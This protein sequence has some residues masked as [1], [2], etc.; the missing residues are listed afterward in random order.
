[1]R[2]YIF[3]VIFGMVDSSKYYSAHE[4][5]LPLPWRKSGEAVEVNSKHF[6]NKSVIL[7]KKHCTIVAELIRN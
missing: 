4:P 3:S 1:M 6:I 2:N 7:K 5:L